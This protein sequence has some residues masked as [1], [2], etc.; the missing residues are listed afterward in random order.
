MQN[1][2]RWTIGH[3]PEI[4][5]FTAHKYA[6]NNHF[7]YLFLNYFQIRRTLWNTL[8]LSLIKSFSYPC[9]NCSF[10]SNCCK[11]DLTLEHILSK[12]F[13]RWVNNRSLSSEGRCSIVPDP[14]RLLIPNKDARLL[15]RSI[16]CKNVL[17]WF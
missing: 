16:Y 1:K 6:I 12:S 4:K 8:Y 2:C 9:S 11:V 7:H 5:K 13:F 14:F 17:F 15:R 3:M 10:L